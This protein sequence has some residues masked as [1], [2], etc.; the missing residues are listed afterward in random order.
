MKSLVLSLVFSTLIT[1]TYGQSDECN[2]TSDCSRGLC[3]FNT[4]INLADCIL[5]AEGEKT[6]D[7]S[8]KT[9]ADVPETTLDGSKKFQKKCLNKRGYGGRCAADGQCSGI[10]DG[11]S[12]MTCSEKTHKCVCKPGFE[13]DSGT[14][15]CNLHQCGM[16]DCP[17]QSDC[18]W[19][20]NGDTICYPPIDCWT[21]AYC[22]FRREDL[23]CL[24]DLEGKRKC[25]KPV[26]HGHAC[27]TDSQCLATKNN[28]MCDL[29][30]PYSGSNGSC[31]CA[32]GFHHVIVSHYDT[33]GWRDECIPEDQ[34]FT[35]TDCYGDSKIWKCSADQRC[36]VRT[37]ECSNDFD[38]Y[39]MGLGSEYRCYDAL[40]ESFPK[41]KR[42][43]TLKKFSQTCESEEEC[44][45]ADENM[46]CGTSLNHLKN[47]ELSCQCKS[48]FEYRESERRCVD[49]FFCRTS[50]DCSK[51]DIVK[52]SDRWLCQEYKCKPILTRETLKPTPRATPRPTTPNNNRRT[53]SPDIN[54]PRI[55]RDPIRDNH[56][57]V[58]LGVVFSTIGI[59][60][61]SL[62]IYIYIKRRNRQNVIFANPM[63]RIQTYPTAPLRC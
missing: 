60:L 46:V 13:Y 12:R 5:N 9:C 18:D 32:T 54:F 59:A 30:Q 41:K 42:C 43:Y 23:K 29:R 24:L 6:C 62:V 39:Q 44:S 56:T 28:T 4:C 11:Y 14:E 45:S 52:G 48:G 25:I 21:D 37:L 36:V 19:R 10:V 1:F 51:L 2:S 58:I 16:G 34:C 57:P 35:D 55:T 40:L 27:T 63:P 49:R 20:D 8:N 53:Q 3:I 47:A 22:S 26:R 38:C 17:Y 31:Q 50:F 15:M 61:A 7:N 33:T